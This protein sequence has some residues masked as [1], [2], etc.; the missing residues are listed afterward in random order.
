MRPRLPRTVLALGAVS[1][2]TDLSSE[3]I[4][5]LLP[6][7]LTTVLAAGPAAN[8]GASHGQALRHFCGQRSA[9]MHLSRSTTTMPSAVLL[10]MAFSG[11]AAMHGGFSQW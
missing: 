10:E 8:W 7:F 9:P 2:L 11:Q 3:M 1:L 6:L 5:P 4:Y